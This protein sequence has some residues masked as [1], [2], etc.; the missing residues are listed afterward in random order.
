MKR[1]IV[2]LS[3][4]LF[5]GG[6]LMAQTPKL[7]YDVLLRNDFSSDPDIMLH[8]PGDNQLLYNQEGVT[9]HVVISD[10]VS[11]ASLYEEDVTGLSTDENGLLHVEFGEGVDWVG[12]GVDWGQA[13]ILMHIT[14]G[15]YT[16]DHSAP[17]YAVPFALQAGNIEKFLTTDAIIEYIGHIN[18]PDDARRILKALHENANGLEQ[19]LVD[20]ITNYLKNHKEQAF[21]G[22][23]YY[24]KHTTADEVQATYNTVTNNTAAFEEGL[25]LLVDYAEQ[26]MDDA[27]EVALYFINNYTTAEDGGYVHDFISTLKANTEVYDV[28]KSYLEDIFKDY[29]DN[30]H[31]IQAKDCPAVN[32]CT[33]H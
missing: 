19:D 8:Y 12:L 22:F 32:P 2:F 4:F 7:S 21:R 1:I 17:I 30:H 26:H 6:I 24:L 31:Y 16:I 11:G 13:N 23:L 25:D 15:G 29:L 27:I 33:I 28:V 10:A 18:F 14:C 5:A 9:A 3:M 20:T